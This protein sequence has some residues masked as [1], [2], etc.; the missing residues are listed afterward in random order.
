MFGN[1]CVLLSMIY[2]GSAV[3]RTIVGPCCVSPLW[4]VVCQGFRVC[5]VFDFERLDNHRTNIH[6]NFTVKVFRSS[7][8]HFTSALC[9][10][11]VVYYHD[12]HRK[13]G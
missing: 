3:D 7:A 8:L 5:F 10:E 6:K 2:I 13:R 9:S 4:E 11:K 12:L 1:S